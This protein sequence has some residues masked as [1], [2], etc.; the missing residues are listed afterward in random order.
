MK[1]RR[2]CP[3]DVGEM[4][5]DSSGKTTAPPVV[6]EILWRQ[7]DESKP[8]RFFVEGTEDTLHVSAST[9]GERIAWV[10]GILGIIS[11]LD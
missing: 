5:V 3:R 6:P 4:P 9:N 10:K 2:G 11:G 7:S 8:F 1:H